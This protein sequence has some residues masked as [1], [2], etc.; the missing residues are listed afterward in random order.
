M[1]RLR[2]KGDADFVGARNISTKTLAALGRVLFPGQKNVG[3]SIRCFRTDSNAF[4]SERT[5]KDRRSR[6]K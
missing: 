1:Y 5:S 2:H 4:R 3:A 6:A